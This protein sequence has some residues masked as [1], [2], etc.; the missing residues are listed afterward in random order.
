MFFMTFLWV[1]LLNMKFV[2]IPLLTLTVC[3]ISMVTFAQV[4]KKRAILFQYGIADAFVNGLYT[5][6]YPVGAL[7]QEGD[8]G[9]GAPDRI[10]GE[11]TMD[12]GTVYQS[13]ATG[14]TIVAPDSL[15]S[16]LAFVCFF[17]PD[18]SF[19][20]SGARGQKEI[21]QRLS[22]YLEH[23]NGMYA[24]RIS[25]L[26][27]HV[28]TRAFPPLTGDSF[29]PLASIL[30]RQHF[31]DYDQ[32]RGVLIGYRM[33]SW[34]AGI[35]IEGFHFHFLSDDL[36][37]GGHVLDFLGEDIRI[38]VAMLEEIRVAAP[39]GRGFEDFDFKR[40]NSPALNKVERGK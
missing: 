6:E 38:E 15:R 26:F 37:K 35:N 30:D 24:I 12:N 18:T 17:R 33:P 27:H 14:E 36:K 28:K 21:L 39:K 10:D 2:L 3:L 32:V 20:M 4:K 1:K 7:K 5:G 23:K 22:G 31:F 9:L 25:G 40:G 16:S 34:L 29:P 11:L 13:K 8:F 19:V